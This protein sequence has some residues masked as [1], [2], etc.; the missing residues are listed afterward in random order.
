MLVRNLVSWAGM[1]FSFVPGQEIDLPDE[2]AE[3][4]IA[5]GL[6]E[7]IEPAAGEAPKRGR[8]K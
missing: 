4:R 2:V 3:A 6:V 5:A 1:D 8:A 7:A